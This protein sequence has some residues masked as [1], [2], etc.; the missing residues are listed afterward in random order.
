MQATEFFPEFVKSRLAAS[1]MY[2]II[3]RQPRTGRLDA[4]EKIVS[5]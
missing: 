4:G 2:K 5:F 3:N 1:L